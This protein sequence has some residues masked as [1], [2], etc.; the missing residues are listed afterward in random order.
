MKQT[1]EH[2]Q[3]QIAELE[4]DNR[5][6]ESIFSQ[7][8]AAMLVTDNLGKIIHFNEAFRRILG[9]DPDE[10]S[11]EYTRSIFL[12]DDPQKSYGELIKAVISGKVWR[13]EHQIRCKSGKVIWIRLIIYPIFHKD[14]IINYIIIINDIN[15][16]KILEIKR[17]EEENLQNALL[18][19]LPLIIALYDLDG[20][21]I[22]AN[23]NT[24]E[25]FRVK[26]GAL[27]G[28]S[29]REIFPPDI[30][31]DQYGNLQKIIKTRKSLLISR[32]LKS[33]GQPVYFRAHHKPMF[34]AKGELKSVLVIGQN[35]TDQVRQ[36]DIV[37]IQH[38][39]DSLSNLTA[40]L[41]SSLKKAFKYLLQ[42]YWVDMGGIYL[43]DEDRKH[44]RLVY[45][46]GLSDDYLKHVSV[47][48]SSDDPANI[49]MK[50]KSHYA[51]TR[52]F[53]EPLKNV[54]KQENLTY[55]VAIPLIYKKEVI[56]SLNLGSKTIEGINQDD[57]SIIEAIATR[58]ANLIMMVKT[59]EKLISA[60][61][62]L[63]RSIREKE[64]QQQR[65]IQKSRLESLGEL[66]AGLAHEINQPLSVISLV[67]ENILYKTGLSGVT[68]EYLTRKFNVINQNI[69]KIRALIE[70][71][72][73]FS[74]DQGSIIFE[75]IDVNKTIRDSVT[76]IGAQFKY[77][78]I[79]I[80]TDLAENLP[81]T[82]GNPSRLEQ[83][84]LNL[85]SNSRDALN[86][87]G[88]IKNEEGLDKEI[89]VNTFL[90][91]KNIVIKFRDNGTGI[92]K[93]NLNSIFNPFFTTKQEGKGTGLGLAIVYGI[94]TEMG[95]TIKVSS[96]EGKFTEINIYLPS[97]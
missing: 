69:E 41:H 59:R 89:R 26:K 37:R 33:D 75:K 7:S 57:R 77:Q 79:K 65:L 5:I 3:K 6:F 53:L 84:M 72:R 54:M 58:L 28:K 18:E 14:E 8:P 92:S 22:Y 63:N 9:Y 29:F 24:D 61:L 30:A 60:N 11:E 39:I 46:S 43:F 36:A 86:D 44:L 19:N 42:I 20:T 88:K 23:D 68:P 38:D 64:E 21:F 35:V 71:V 93:E 82:L 13:G 48:S 90:E 45:S 32:S 49:I 97:Y 56:G 91:D 96:E 16:Q 74:R 1:V 10:L 51:S 4:Q 12:G 47:F 87:V 2:L 94:V 70:H 95:G 85:F 34:D 80:V 76:L 66:S 52:T 62:M 55:I 40:N 25:F 17:Q 73:L 27:T 67:M 50:G 78:Q 83:V 31:D 15:D 81:F